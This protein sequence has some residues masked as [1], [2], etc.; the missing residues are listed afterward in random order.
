[1]S[2]VSL[3]A[4][5]EL[6]GTVTPA[7]SNAELYAI[8]EEEELGGLAGMRRRGGGCAVVAG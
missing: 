3:L 2:G 4:A 7:R 1:M 6:D 8:L 5:W